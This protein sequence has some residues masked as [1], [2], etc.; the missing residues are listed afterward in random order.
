MHAQHGPNLIRDFGFTAEVIDIQTNKS[1]ASP[2]ATA[3][4]AAAS[5]AAAPSSG[6]DSSHSAID[7]VFAPFLD[8][9]LA[10]IKQR[11][12]LFA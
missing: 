2:A 8:N 5:L 1:S 3:Q 6:T 7:A 9:P 4:L 11:H 10:W 12:R